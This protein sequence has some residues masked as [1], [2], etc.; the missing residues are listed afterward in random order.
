MMCDYCEKNK[1]IVKVVGWNVWDG[2]PETLVDIQDRFP[3]DSTL[4]AECFG[5]VCQGNQRSQ[6]REWSVIVKGVE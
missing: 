4:C 5:E 3:F 6:D 1:S 2:N